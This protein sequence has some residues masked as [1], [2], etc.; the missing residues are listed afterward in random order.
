MGGNV[1]SGKR[2]SQVAFLVPGH[3]SAFYSMTICRNCIS[4]RRRWGLCSRA[5]VLYSG[6]HHAA[7]SACSRHPPGRGSSSRSSQ[8]VVSDLVLEEFG[9]STKGNTL[10]LPPQGCSC[11]QLCDYQVDVCF[12]TGCS[13]YAAIPTAAAPC[14]TSNCESPCRSRF[15]LLINKVPSKRALLTEVY[16]LTVPRE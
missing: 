2:K 15:S 9:C 14:A 16:A 1:S 11:P 6:S 3:I 5:P 12:W 7:G 4:T 10:L 13:L 8:P